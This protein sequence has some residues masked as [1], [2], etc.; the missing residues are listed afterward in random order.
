[1]SVKLLTEQCFELP[2][3]KGG[4]TG[5]SEATLVEMPHCWKSRV[6]AHTRGIWKVLSMALKLHNA[7]IKYYQIIHLWKLEFNGYI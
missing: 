6:T 4:Y 1:M 5:S 7:L 2:R 3:L